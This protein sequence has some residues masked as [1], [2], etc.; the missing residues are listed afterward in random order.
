MVDPGGATFSLMYLPAGTIS[1]PTPVAAIIP[2]T[3]SL[4]ATLG[5]GAVWDIALKRPTS[6]NLSATPQTLVLCAVYPLG[7]V[8]S[9]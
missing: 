6:D 9:L 8:P 4:R 3:P 1:L 5:L 7:Q 2:L